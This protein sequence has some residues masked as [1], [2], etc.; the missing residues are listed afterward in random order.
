MLFAMTV[1]VSNCSRSARTLCSVSKLSRHIVRKFDSCLFPSEN[2]RRNSV[3]FAP[4]DVLYRAMTSDNEISPAFCLRWKIST[5]AAR[6]PSFL[7][8]LET[9]RYYWFLYISPHDH[10]RACGW[11]SV[12]REC[13]CT[14]VCVFT[15]SESSGVGLCVIY[16]SAVG[17]REKDDESFRLPFSNRLDS[18]HQAKGKLLYGASAPCRIDLCA[19]LLIENHRSRFSFRSSGS[20][21]PIALLSRNNVPNHSPLAKCCKQ[22]SIS[23]K[24]SSIFRSHRVI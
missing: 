4:S 15:H 5:L 21:E 18:G 12:F 8:L 22:W 16:S 24:F 14:R 6:S 11:T 1:S 19:S 3:G 7:V 23:L 17:R 9:A 20:I 10:P 2:T 13:A